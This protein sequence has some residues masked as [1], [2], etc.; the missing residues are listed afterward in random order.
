MTY[1][2]SIGHVTDDVKWPERS[3]RDPNTLSAQ[4]RLYLVTFVDY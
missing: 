4:L 3:S 2:E 1:E